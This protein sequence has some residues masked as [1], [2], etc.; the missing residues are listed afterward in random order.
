MPVTGVNL[1]N[2]VG[3]SIDM[4]DAD[5]ENS[6]DMQSPTTL[7]DIEEIARSILSRG[8]DPD[9]AI[10]VR[11]RPGGRYMVTDGNK[12]RAA[13]LRA[14][15]LGAKIEL[16][17]TRSEIQGTNEETRAVLRLRAPGRELS[18]LEAVIDI[19]RLLGWHWSKEKIAEQLGKNP[20]W[21]DR[22][23]D[24]AAA[25]HEIREA[26]RTQE[27]AP[28]EAR[29]LAR[30]ADPVNALRTVREHANAAGRTRIRTRDVDAVMKPRTEGVSLCTLATIAVRAYRDW[31]GDPGRLREIF[32]AIEALETRLGPLARKEAA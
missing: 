26:V 5:P 16:I 11:S 20:D 32:A 12:R 31:N 3:R 13:F 28:T 23:L 15:E 7:A 17:A 10:L 4:I 25:P 2:I 18:P 27:I 1:A 19:N 6:R 8:F 30:E 9:R 24:L 14:R 22:C 21:I 29:K